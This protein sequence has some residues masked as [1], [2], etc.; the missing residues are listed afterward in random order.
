MDKFQVSKLTR[1]ILE[2]KHTYKWKTMD[3]LFIETFE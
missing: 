3:I 2:F 1:I